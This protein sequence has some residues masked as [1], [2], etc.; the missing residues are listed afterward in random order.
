ML[1]II[2]NNLNL[3]LLKEKGFNQLIQK[4]NQKMKLIKKLKIKKKNKNNNNNNN[5]VIII[6]SYLYLKKINHKLL[7]LKIK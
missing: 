4:M 1:T 7:I 6:N 5:M 2:N 3:R